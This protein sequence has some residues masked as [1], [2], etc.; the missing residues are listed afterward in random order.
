MWKKYFQ[1]VLFNKQYYIK[2]K[3]HSNNTQNINEFME[4][5]QSP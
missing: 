5:A 2:Y 1:S 3:V 4:D